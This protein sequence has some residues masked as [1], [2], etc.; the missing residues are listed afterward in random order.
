MMR[1]KKTYR[2]PAVTNIVNENASDD[3]ENVVEKN[4]ES[5]L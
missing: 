2:K 4:G 1:T 3:K 5:H